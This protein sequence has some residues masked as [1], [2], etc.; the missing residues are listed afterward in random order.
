MKTAMS[1][2]EEVREHMGVTQAQ[3]AAWLD[4][5]LRTY[6][7]KK[8]KGFKPIDLMA[9][10]WVYLKW[11]AGSELLDQRLDALWPNGAAG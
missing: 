3:F 8:R 2:P 5:P 1:S 7:D 6:E 9:A 10:K 11:S 4:M